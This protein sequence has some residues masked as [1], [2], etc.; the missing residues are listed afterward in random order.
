MEMR[1]F[2]LLEQWAQQ[3]LQVIHHPGQENLGDYPS[4]HHTGPI[5]T[6]VRPYYLHMPNSPLLL[7]RAALPSSRRG[8]AETLGDPY[9]SKTPLPRIPVYREHTQ[10]R[11]P[12]TAAAAT[13]ISVQPSLAKQIL[14]RVASLA[15]AAN[16]YT[17]I[18]HTRIGAVCS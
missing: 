12:V 16:S 18:T 4:K 10:L 11:A 9:H 17:K 1:Y 5:H 14:C 6:H 2:W 3:N 13:A 8:C 15:S 7:P